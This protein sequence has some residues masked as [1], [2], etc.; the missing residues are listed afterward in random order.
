[1]TEKTLLNKQYNLMACSWFVKND[2]LRAKKCN[3]VDAVHEETNYKR[4]LT[5]PN[6][7]REIQARSNAMYSS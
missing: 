1:M 7:T 4:A 2:D 6:A 3:S 5:S